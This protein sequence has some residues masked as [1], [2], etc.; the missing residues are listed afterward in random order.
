[1]PRPEDLPQLLKELIQ[2]GIALTSERDPSV[3][4]KMILLEAR[5]FT[6][7]EAGTLFL[8]EGDQLRPAVVQNDLL[9]DRLGEPE[10][11]RLQAEPLPLSEE[12]LAG[13][14][15][16]TGEI[17]NLP[18]ASAIPPDRPYTF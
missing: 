9:A 18:D 13:Y 6:R 16:L 11:G 12:S 17:L 10:L 5:R 15:A 7:A 8:R 2:I 4:L 14:V 3:L 1:M